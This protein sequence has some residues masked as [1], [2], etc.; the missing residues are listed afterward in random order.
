ME[1]M[2]DFSLKE[3]K[4]PNSCHSSFNLEKYIFM[5]LPLMV[6]F[7]GNDI[8]PWFKVSVSVSAS[9]NGF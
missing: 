5:F 9:V 7:S 3:E 6:L 4:I 2:H 1:K 8:C